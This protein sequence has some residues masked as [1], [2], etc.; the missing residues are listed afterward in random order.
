MSDDC[1][2][3]RSLL[4]RI[5]EIN[6]RSPWMTLTQVE[7]YLG[8]NPDRRYKAV[9]R[10]LIEHGIKVKIISGNKMR[11]SREQVDKAMR[12]DQQYV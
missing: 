3:L 12:N 5:E 1:E 11:V 2:V 6:M 7:R 9:K 10:F 4:S 8:F